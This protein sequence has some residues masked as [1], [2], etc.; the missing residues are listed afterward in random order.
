MHVNIKTKVP[1]DLYSGAIRTA[2]VAYNMKS[3]DYDKQIP[4]QLL[5]KEINTHYKETKKGKGEVSLL[6]IFQ[7]M[8][9]KTTKNNNTEGGNNDN[10]N[11]F[12]N[13][14]KK[15]EGICHFCRIKGHRKN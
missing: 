3:D 4:P 12:G 15:F 5:M 11:K 2:K 13:N 9:G 6:N 14:N 10:A 1:A 8:M 7:T